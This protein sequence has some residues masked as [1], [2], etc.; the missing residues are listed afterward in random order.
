MPIDLDVALDDKK[1]AR[2]KE[3]RGLL[4]C[5]EPACSRALSLH[6]RDGRRTVRGVAPSLAYS[7]FAASFAA[8]FEA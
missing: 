3:S 6:T 7:A 8:M 1:A 2:L 5:C 4:L